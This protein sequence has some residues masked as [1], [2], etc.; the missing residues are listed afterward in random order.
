M[1]PFMKLLKNAQEKLLG[2][3]A[4][5]P[6]PPQRLRA[7]AELFAR[8]NP[9]ATVAEWLDFTA[10]HANSA[11][12][13]GYVRGFERG[14]RLGPDWEDPDEAAKLIEHLNE[15]ALG[16]L[17]AFDPSAVVPVEGFPQES[18]AKTAIELNRISME[19][20]G[21]RRGPARK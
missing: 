9:K 2:T 3:F 18:A 21:Q 8:A 14:E 20:Q 10:K 15:V 19:Q 16:N 7:L 17:P 4:E 11:Y 13:Q 12:Q 6:D 5:G 1:T